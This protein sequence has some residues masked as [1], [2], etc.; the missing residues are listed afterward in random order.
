MCGMVQ[1]RSLKAARTRSR[2]F[3][4]AHNCFIGLNAFVNDL[5]Q[6]SFGWGSLSLSIASVD[7]L[8]RCL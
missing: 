8:A 7:S 3:K 1:S 2:S 5:V 6:S 4:V